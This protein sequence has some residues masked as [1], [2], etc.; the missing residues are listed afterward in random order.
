MDGINSSKKDAIELSKILN[1][2]K[3]KV[4]IIP[5]NETDGKYKRPTNETINQFIE[6][7]NLYN[8]NF[9]ILIRWSNGLDIDA[10]CGQLAISNNIK[11]D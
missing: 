7:L 10:G 6:T 8:K 5:Y 3:C 9:Q 11:G 4:N 1:S 2:A